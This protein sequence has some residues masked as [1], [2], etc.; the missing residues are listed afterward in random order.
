M[1][2]KLHLAP[3]A[4]QP[5]SHPSPGGSGPC[6]CPPGSRA[7]LDLARFLASQGWGTVLSVHFTW[8]VTVAWLGSQSCHE[9]SLCQGRRWQA[10]NLLTL[11]K[12]GLDLPPRTACLVLRPSFCAALRGL[13]CKMAQPPALCGLPAWSWSLWPMSPVSGLEPAS[14][15][16]LRVERPVH[17]SPRAH[18]GPDQL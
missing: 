8:S 5:A 12:V 18:L 4:R 7:D 11:G 10:D 9:V 3:R 14:S 1:H 6:L 13:F 2:P 16:A 17:L 15:P